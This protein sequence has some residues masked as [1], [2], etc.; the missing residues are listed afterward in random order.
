[1][2]DIQGG[3]GF[4]DVPVVRKSQRQKLSE[5][6]GSHSVPTDLEPLFG[7]AFVV[8]VVGR[9]GENQIHRLRRHEMFY[10]CSK[11]GVSAEHPMVTKHPHVA[12]NRNGYL[13]QFR[14][15]ILVLEPVC[16]FLLGEQF[17]QVLVS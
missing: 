15:R 3:A 6:F 2:S 4:D 11:S 1:V 7:V 17:R 8:D 10:V 5:L 9:I 14:N 13:R 12:R 16:R